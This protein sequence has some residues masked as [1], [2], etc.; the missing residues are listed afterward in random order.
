MR[1]STEC[2]EGDHNVKSFEGRAYGAFKGCVVLESDS[3]D[4][5][6]YAIQRNK[7]GALIYG[8]KPARK[9]YV[10][11]KVVSFLGSLLFALQHVDWKPD[12]T[13]SFNRKED[14]DGQWHVEIRLTD[15]YGNVYDKGFVTKKTTRKLAKYH[16]LWEQM[17]MKSDH[18][19]PNA[20]DNMKPWRR[21][22][23]HKFILNYCNGKV[24]TK[25][26]SQELFHEFY[27]TYEFDE[28]CDDDELKT[29]KIIKFIIGGRA[30][31]LTLLEFTQ[32]L[33]LYHSEELDKEGFD[34][35]FQGEDNWMKRKGAGT[36]R[37]SM[38]CCRQFITKIARKPR[39]LSN[40][41]IKSL[42]AP[43]YYIDLD[44]TT[45]RELIDSKG[46]LIP[47]ALQPDVPRVAILRLRRASMQDLSKRIGSMEIRQGVIERMAYRQSFH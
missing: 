20:L 44:T 17:M 15:P 9:I 37:D 33:G 28:V 43:I 7:F 5:E 41:V 26:Q 1:G 31:S 11:K 40:E 18:Q 46:R 16:K 25:M 35:Y 27:S 10:W 36:Q 21:Y 45:L 42:S 30:H 34:V 2:K 6:E 24:T 14:G 29:K 4:E 23:S 3:D 38:I 32:R 22:C 47:E 13:G 12:Y 19:D 8:P 39:V